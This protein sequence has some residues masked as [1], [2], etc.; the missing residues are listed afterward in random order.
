MFGLSE[1][2]PVELGLALVLIWLIA[3][4]C[5]IILHYDK[6]LPED[7]F[8]PCPGHCHWFW[9]FTSAITQRVIA[10][11]PQAFHFYF[12][13]LVEAIKAPT[14]RVLWCRQLISVVMVTGDSNCAENGPCS[15]PGQPRGRRAR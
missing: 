11:R 15:E 2:T 4:S 13:V 1:R 3:S 10:D 6:N 14:A 12:R 8:P 7:K 5:E 9:T